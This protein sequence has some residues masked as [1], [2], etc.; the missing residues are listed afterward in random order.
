MSLQQD[1]QCSLPWQQHRRMV[2]NHKWSAPRMSALPNP[3]QYLLRENNGWRTWRPWRKHLKIMKEPS[4]S[5]ADIDSLAGQERELVKLVITL[6]RP[7]LHMACRSVHR[8]PSW[9]QITPKASALTLLQTTKNWRPY[10]VFNIRE[11]KYRMRDLSPKYSTGPV[12]KT[13]E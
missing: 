9:W 8:R 11:L 7:P 13:R 10:V 4:A 3:L 2:P 5:E 12:V 6:K 1:D